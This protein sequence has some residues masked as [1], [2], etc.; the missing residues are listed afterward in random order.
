MSE[1]INL[2]IPI[3]NANALTRAAD[4]LHGMAID[5]SKNLINH[6]LMSHEEATE[7]EPV[8]VES[9]INTEVEAEFV[10]DKLDAEGTPWDERIHSSSKSFIKNGTWKL[11]RGV[12]PNFV[13]K[14]KEEWKSVP[15]T[16][17]P[18]PSV[19]D[20]EPAPAPPP[21]PTIDTFPDLMTEIAAKGI[22]H[23][24]VNE[25]VNKHGAGSLAILAAKPELIPA[26]AAELFS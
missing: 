25:I 20:E 2:T 11:K 23:N 8:A 10:S 21:A 4:M 5:A 18:A 16:E 24:T 26:V 9:A 13:A 6:N 15:I 22:D 14:I 7:E 3:N 19:F 17:E 1:T 12:D